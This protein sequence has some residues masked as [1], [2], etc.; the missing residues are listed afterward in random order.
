MQNYPEDSLRP[1]TIKQVLEGTISGDSAAE[2]RIDGVAVSQ[3]TLVGQIRALAPQQTLV[4]L[5]LD[6]GT[7][8]VDVKK[9]IDPD[10]H[11][12]SLG[13]LQIDMHVHVWGKLKPFGGKQ[14]VQ[15]HIIRPVESI[16]EVNCHMLEASYVHL[17][18]TRGPPGGGANSNTTNNNNKNNNSDSLFVDDGRGHDPSAAKLDSCRPGSRRVHAHLASNGGTEGLHLQYIANSLGMSVRDVMQAAEELLSMGLIY[19]TADDETWAIMET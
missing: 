14:V 19:T 3:V 16:D 18:M 10:K 12:D 15:A 2:T 11:D 1:V 7:G 5:R 9:Y 8:T 6:D 4:S 13:G 17:Y